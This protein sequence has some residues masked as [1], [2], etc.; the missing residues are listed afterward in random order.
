MQNLLV[1]RL[2]SVLIITGLTAFIFIPTTADG[3]W[4]SASRASVG[5]APD[6]IATSEAVV[7][8]YGARAYS[9]GVILAFIPGSL[10]NPPTPAPTPFT[11]YLAGAS[12]DNYRYWRSMTKSRTGAGLATCRS[13]L[14]INAAKVLT[15]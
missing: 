15:R 3:N 11:K 5:I 9:G 12:A 10:S 2:L 1:Q 4:R 13:S 6:P 7:Q 14:Q 8:V